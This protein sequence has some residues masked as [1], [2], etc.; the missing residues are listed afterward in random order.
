MTIEELISSIEKESQLLPSAIERGYSGMKKV[1]ASKLKD[2]GSCDVP[3]LG[4]FQKDSEK[5]KLESTKTKKPAEKPEKDDK[6]EDKP[7]KED[8]KDQETIDEKSETSYEQLKQEADNSFDKQASL[9][10]IPYLDLSGKNISRDIL[11]Y[12]PEHI[13][14]RFQIVPI[15]EKNG[16]LIVS[17]IDPEDQETI[18]LIKKRTKLPLI[19]T[20]CTQD[21]LNHVID[22][23]SGINSDVNDLVETSGETL[24]TTEE[25]VKDEEEEITETSDHAPAAKVVDSLFKRAVREKASDIHIEPMEDE[26]IVRF[27]VDGVLRK[28]VSLPKM[29]HPAIV[30]RIKILSNLKIDEQRLPQ[31]GRF[32]IK[33]NQNKIDFRIS[34]LPTVNGEKVVARILDKSSGILTLENLGM[35]GSPYETLKDNINKSHGM[36]LVTGPTGSGKSTTLYAVLDQVKDI[37]TNII[38]LEDPVEYRMTGINQ[39]QINSEIGYTFASGLRSILRQDP[40]IVMVGEIRDFDTANIAIHAALTG[41]VVFSTIHTNNAAGTIP[42]LIDM[43]IEPFL[44][45]SSVNAIV[46]QRLCRKICTKCKQEISPDASTKQAVAEEIAKMPKGEQKAIKDQKYFK[47]KGCTAC[48]DTGYKGRIGI[49]E[50]LPVTEKIRLITTRE[51]SADTIQE[52]AIAGGM[53]TMKQDGILKAMDGLTTIEEIWRVT[54]D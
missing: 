18:E 14:K 38:T 25:D 26:I 2:E 22:Q 33:L 54:K 28:I 52:T 5:V 42:R 20:L 46:A 3:H 10:A 16:D 12:I 7:E 9:A 51:T 50:V 40:N 8:I 21:D 41:H 1:L 47:G 31:D 48:G 29:L 23:Y 4:M 30:S 15:E 36:I 49:Y 37:A 27:R 44:I 24:E 53:I 17:M 19:V 32:Q 45:C 39:C 43:D 11:S 34:T 6:P 13:A 35:R